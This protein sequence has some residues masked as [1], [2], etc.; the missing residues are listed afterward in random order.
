MLFCR[1]T[2]F[3]EIEITSKLSHVLLYINKPSKF[4]DEGELNA[5]YVDFVKVY[6]T[7]SHK[8]IHSCF[9]AFFYL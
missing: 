3:Y 7:V 2:V 8:T 1:I 5:D 6:D 4:I 9:S